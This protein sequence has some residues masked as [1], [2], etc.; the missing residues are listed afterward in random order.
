MKQALEARR[1]TRVQGRVHVDSQAL[2][3]QLV[4]LQCGEH[5]QCCGGGGV[6]VR[7]RHRS[8]LKLF[9]RHIAKSPDDGTATLRS[10]LIADRAK[11]DQREML[12][13]TTDHVA[14]LA[15]SMKDL[16]SADQ[17]QRC[18]IGILS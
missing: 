4:W 17:V 18:Y 8:P 13:R 16:M 9:R 10:Q 12:I 11:I 3:R 2:M 1:Y 7:S 14:R 6:H 15:V 5:R